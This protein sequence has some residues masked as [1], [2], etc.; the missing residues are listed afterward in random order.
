[1]HCISGSDEELEDLKHAYTRWRGDMDRIM[2]SV[3]CATVEDEPRFRQNLGNL[4]A[5]GS[6]EAYSAFTNE[7]KSKAAARKRK[8]S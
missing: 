6:V 5:D 1:M 4:I 7:R 3:M 8:V 2:E